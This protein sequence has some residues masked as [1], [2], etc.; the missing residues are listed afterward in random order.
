MAKR[1]IEVALCI[2]QK[3]LWKRL[4]AADGFVFEIPGEDG[5]IAAHIAGSAGERD[6]GLILH[7]DG[8]D[9]LVDSFKGNEDDGCNYLALIMMTLS[10]VPPESRGLLMTANWNARRDAIV[11][12][13][14]VKPQ[15]GT[16]VPPRRRDVR[17]AL[18]AASAL[19]DAIRSDRFEAVKMDD[20]DGLPLLK[21]SGPPHK[22]DIE[23]S[24]FQL[25]T[26]LR[27]RL[28]DEALDQH[29]E[30]TD[31]IWCIDVFSLETHGQQKNAV[32]VLPQDSDDPLNVDLD[33]GTKLADAV[34][35]VRKFA[36][37]EGD[38]N[39]IPRLPSEMWW[40]DDALTKKP[41]SFFSPLGVLCK[42]VPDQPN[43][44][45]VR[46]RIHEVVD[47]LRAS[48]ESI[49]APEGWQRWNQAVEDLRDAMYRYAQK[50][51]VDTKQARARF[52]GSQDAATAILESRDGENVTDG[53]L[54]WS[55][56]H[57]PV[58]SGT[59]THLD[60]IVE[61]GNAQGD[62]QIVAS[63]LLCARPTV[64]SRG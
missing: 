4:D 37:A 54:T 49:D 46:T 13:L 53:Y 23:W 8:L 47:S 61:Q 48:N 31:E 10:D 29:A 7:R 42:F 41:D 40:T 34:E 57:G 6:V 36:D 19:L 25:S 56:C 18:F 60:A 17:T 52:F 45:Q 9:G 22:P 14:F 62:A 59:G 32:T 55:I 15:H 39:D 51:D 2:H 16:F 30:Q 64:V 44:T 28:A 33:A 5:P 24:R 50:H 3:D 20:P 35:S 26:E 43:A 58:S 1:L 63:A 21:L 38:Y 11:P 27:E 12:L